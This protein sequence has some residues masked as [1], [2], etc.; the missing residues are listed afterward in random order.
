VAAAFGGALLGVAAFRIRHSNS[1]SIGPRLPRCD[2]RRRLE[3][4][5]RLKSVLTGFDRAGQ[6][7]ERIPP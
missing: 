2:Q 5:V 7:R 3:G 6:T 1:L 4:P